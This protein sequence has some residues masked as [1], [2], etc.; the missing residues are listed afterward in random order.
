MI[1]TKQ[2]PQRV[3][4]TADTVGGVWTYAIELSR[5]LAAHGI[6]VGLATMGGRLNLSQQA[7]VASLSNV[8]VFESAF[9]LEWMDEP[10]ADIERAAHWLLEL[11]E[12]FHPDVVHLNNFAHG[13]FPWRAPKIV[14]GHSCVLSWWRA[15][16]GCDAPSE[17]DE[18]RES[19]M[20]GLHG[21]ELVVAPSHAM[22]DA[23]NDHYGPFKSSTVIH[24]GRALPQ[25]EPR[26]KHDF[27]FSAGRLWDAGKNVAILADVASKLS[28]PVMVAGQETDPDGRTMP[29]RNLSYLGPLS[30]SEMFSYFERAKIYALPAR[31][32]PFGLSA[33]E[34]ALAGCALVLGDIPSLREIWGDAALFVSPDDP[35]ALESTLQNLINHPEEIAR[36]AERSQIA[37]QQY[38]P[39]KMAEGYLAAYESILRK[40][41]F[42]SEFTTANWSATP[43]TVAPVPSH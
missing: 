26:S 12:V 10:R 27:I 29:Q 22:L 28:W 18:Y 42:V 3:L 33:L 14:V 2:V 11:E 20:A 21:A 23:L 5:A 35:A 7:D 19:V 43:E 16:H 17:W 25:L 6:E 34:A 37:A 31:Y 41:S 36:L 38:T 40:S 32:E 9:K 24:N 1:T 4:M 8:K 15:V 30:S 13:A 39:E